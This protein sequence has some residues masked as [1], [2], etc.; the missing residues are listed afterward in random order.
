[1]SAPPPRGRLRATEQGE[2]ISNSYGLRRIALR[3][4]EKAVFAVML[5][6]FETPVPADFADLLAALREDARAVER[7]DPRA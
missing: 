2:G 6:S 5:D 7:S 3:T 1:M 4:F